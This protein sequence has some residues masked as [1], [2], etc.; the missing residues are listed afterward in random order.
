MAKLGFTSTTE[1]ILWC[2]AIMCYCDILSYSLGSIFYKYMIVF[3]FITVI[4]VFLLFGLCI[5]IVQLP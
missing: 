4:Y 1:N 5:L 2:G 3:L